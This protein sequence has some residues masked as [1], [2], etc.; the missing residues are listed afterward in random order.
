MNVETVPIHQFMFHNLYKGSW[1]GRD[2]FVRKVDNMEHKLFW[3]RFVLPDT[4][5]A[6]QMATHTNVHKLLGC[7]LETITPVLVYEWVAPQTLE[8]CIL[9]EDE[10][11]NQRVV[12]E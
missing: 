9:L 1:E 12:V 2:V 7:C 8:D 3:E 5:V 4:V 11:Q 6:T 10:I